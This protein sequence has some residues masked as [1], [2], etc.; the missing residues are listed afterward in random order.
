M[1][2]LPEVEVVRAGVEPVLVGRRIVGVRCAAQRL[3]HLSARERFRRLA[4]GRVMVGVGRR[5]KY[6]LVRL[7]SGA[8]IV[9]HFGMTGRL[10]FADS[11]DPPLPHD[12]VCFELDGE[13]ELRFNDARRF[14]SIRIHAAGESMPELDG[15]GPEPLSRRF[16]ATTLLASARARS[17]P[18]KNLLM[19]G[20]VVAGVGNIY[21]NEAL[22]AAGVNPY[23]P[24]RDLTEGE[25]GTIVR[26]LRRIL[27]QAIA[28]GGSSISDFLGSDGKAGYFQLA[29]QAYG[30]HGQSCQRCG[31]VIR[32]EVQAGRATFFCPRCQR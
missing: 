25:A 31:G 26:C 2:E 5:A 20:R 21:A 16:S 6:L 30:R 29:F 17:Q 18:V 3:R 12:H 7:D 27:R 32:R 15:L 22:F 1:P 14:G 8:V 19:D 23:K 10:R 4:V 24:A 9:L 11:G 28:A 13:I